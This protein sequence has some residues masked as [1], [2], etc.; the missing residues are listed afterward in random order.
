MI[1]N[2]FCIQIIFCFA[3]MKHNRFFYMMSELEL[4]MQE[5]FMIFVKP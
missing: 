4:R 3:E 5:P 2:F 1:Q